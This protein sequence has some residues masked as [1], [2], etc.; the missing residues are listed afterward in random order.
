MCSCAL[1]NVSH[2]APPSSHPVSPSSI[3]V[4]VVRLTVQLHVIH[5]TFRTPRTV[6]HELTLTMLIINWSH[7]FCSHGPV[8]HAHSSCH[9]KIGL[10]LSNVTCF[11]RSLPSATLID[12]VNFHRFVPDWRSGTSQMTQAHTYTVPSLLNTDFSCFSLCMM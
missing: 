9:Q 8:F 1:C 6:S 11:L 12:C 3:L 4:L 5:I 10:P 2:P 7:G